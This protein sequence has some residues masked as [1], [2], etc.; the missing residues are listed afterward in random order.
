MT[1]LDGLEPQVRAYVS[2]ML[3][4]TGNGWE[5]PKCSADPTMVQ[6]AVQH[7]LQG[8]SGVLAYIMYG[9]LCWSSS[10]TTI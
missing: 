8:D 1:R 5:G 6:A 2:R 4:I 7:S 3:E 9:Q 10:P